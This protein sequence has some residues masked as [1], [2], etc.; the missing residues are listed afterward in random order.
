MWQRFTERARKVIFF[1]QEESQKLGHDYVGPE[2]ILLGLIRQPDSIAARVLE[3]L[4]VSLEKIMADTLSV[5]SHSEP[6][7]HYDLTLTSRFK[8]VI[9]LAFDEARSLNN[10]HIGT[11]HLLLALIR[12]KDSIAAGVLD[13]NGI[14][15]EEARQTVEELQLA[16]GKAVKSRPYTEPPSTSSLLPLLAGDFLGEHIVICLSADE[17]GRAGKLI[18]AQCADVGALQLLMWERINAGSKHGVQ[19]PTSGSL[20]SLL[21]RVHSEAEGGAVDPVHLFLALLSD[22]DSDLPKALAGH[23]I[24]LERSRELVKESA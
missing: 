20:T 23:G 24:S 16:G 14:T 6:S 17:E 9:E 8:R 1:A 10:N 21:A 11:E 3:K 4:N 13:R 2:H 18:R 22:S 12:E 7:S 19:F 5:L 15:L